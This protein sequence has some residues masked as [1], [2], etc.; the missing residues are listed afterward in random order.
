MQRFIVV[1]VTLLLG[2]LATAHTKIATTVPADGGTVAAPK[3]I[4][5][6]F[7]GDVRLTSLS[8]TDAAG[9][10]QPIDAVPTS[11][12]ARFA[13]RLPQPLPPGDYVAAWRAVGGDTHVVSG[14]FRFTVTAAP[15]L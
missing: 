6:E 3:E 9:R 5:L 10:E 14:E 8:V 13:V 1:L 4:V 15:A 7:G 12:A 11:I 2:A